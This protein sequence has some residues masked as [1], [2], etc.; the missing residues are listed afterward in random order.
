MSYSKPNHTPPPKPCPLEAPPALPSPP[1]AVRR[2]DT[3]VLGRNL[4][5]AMVFA[6]IEDHVEAHL[7]DNESKPVAIVKA[8]PCP[9]GNI[10][11]M[12]ADSEDEPVAKPECIDLTPDTDSDDEH[13]KPDIKPARIEVK[14]K[15]SSKASSK[16]FS[17]SDG[18]VAASAT[19]G[20]KVSAFPQS[21][22]RK[23]KVSKGRAWR[24]DRNHRVRAASPPTAAEYEDMSTIPL[25][26]F[27]FPPKY[28]RKLVQMVWCPHSREGP[29]GFRPDLVMRE[30]NIVLARE[31]YVLTLTARC[32]VEGGFHDQGDTAAI[33]SFHH[34]RSASLFRALDVIMSCT[35][36]IKKGDTG[37][38]YHDYRL[39]YFP[40][41]SGTSLIRRGKNASYLDE[42]FNT[43]SISNYHVRFGVF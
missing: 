18:A 24:T 37:D 27:N 31:F 42:F 40:V 12:D 9:S 17:S 8:E 35:R 32:Y 5:S 22:P 34:T 7:S 4:D 14:V 26:V 36:R 2:S 3:P 20:A 25:A 19:S 30:D 15:A 39:P 13:A 43:G 21:S 23:R 11:V 16:V 10:V 41:H 6:A 1:D 28:E 38:L 29:G 33:T